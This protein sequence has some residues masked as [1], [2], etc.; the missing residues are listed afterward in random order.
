MAT[1]E[2]LI[3]LQMTRASFIEGIYTESQEESIQQFGVTA[4]DSK[5]VMLETYWV[6]LEAS[7]EKLVG[8]K[9]ENLT[10]LDY[11]KNQ[12]FD[13]AL[14]HYASGRVALLQLLEKKGA[15]NLNQS[16]R[17]PS[18]A[19]LLSSTRR[20][21][22]EIEFPKF[23][24]VSKEWRPWRDL[25]HSLVGNNLEIPGVERMHYL[26]LC[27]SNKPLKL[28]S[29][30]PVSEDSF[31]I[32]WRILVDRYENKRLLITA[33]LDQLLNPAPM[34]THGASDLNL[35]TSSVSEAL[36]ALK[37]LDQP[38]DHWGPIVVHVLTRRLSNKLREAWE[39]KIGAST[40]Y[41]THEHLLDFLQGRSR[42]MD[43]LEVGSSVH[44][45]NDASRPSQLSVQTRSM[46]N[47]SAKVNQASVSSHAQQSAQKSP[48]PAQIQSTKSTS[49]ANAGYPCSYCKMDH[50]IASCSGFK[51]L[52]PT[53]RKEVVERLYLCY[54]CLGKH[55]IRVC[56]TTRTCRTCQERHHSL[57][58]FDR[59][60]RPAQRGPASQVPRNDAG[61][62]RP[63]AS[64]PSTNVPVVTYTHTGDAAQAASSAHS[65][66]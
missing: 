42:A 53:A 17:V 9:I 8:Q 2:A 52:T 58:H 16:V 10:S 30:L 33:H 26:R 63:S 46:T 49:W 14:K 57:L 37:A 22:P 39:N 41:P 61:A 24:G 4:L 28:I 19:Q 50:Y 27:L 56:Q 43:T 47:S 66:A 32:A 59:A 31:G 15:P 55:S 51:S 6:K 45:S 36:S 3:S 62:Q 60:R 18:D 7:H 44:T 13:V 5:L 21:L 25:F 35:L 29:N 20:A 64:A 34:K 38:T 48:S 40:E 12:V 11:F 1:L 54:N 65:Q 23:S